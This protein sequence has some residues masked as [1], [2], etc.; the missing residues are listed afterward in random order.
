MFRNQDRFFKNG[1]EGPM[2]VWNGKTTD[3]E[4]NR[5]L[6]A[7][8]P[9]HSR[10][11]SHQECMSKVKYRDELIYGLQSCLAA[12]QNERNLLRHKYETPN[13]E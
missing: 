10:W 11:E 13:K 6:D 1:S 7:T 2:V 3:E 12:L 9:E 5:F 4:I 8:V